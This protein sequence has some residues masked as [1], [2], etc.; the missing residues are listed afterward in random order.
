MISGNKSAGITVWGKDVKV[1]GNL[2]GTNAGGTA[3]IGN[4]DGIVVYTDGADRVTTAL[5]AVW[6]L[7][8]GT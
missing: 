2:I 3:A 6:R 7:G 5:L 1:I 8:L 4:S